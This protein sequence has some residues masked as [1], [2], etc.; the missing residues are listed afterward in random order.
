MVTCE[1]SV[2]ESDTGTDALPTVK[3]S[4][5][6][7]ERDLDFL[8]EDM[9]IPSVLLSFSLSLFS[10]IQVLMSSIMFGIKRKWSGI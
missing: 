3:E 8:P 4:W 10:V 6:E 7:K 2:T 1:S 9:V 5:K